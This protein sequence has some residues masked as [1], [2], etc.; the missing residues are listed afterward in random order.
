MG[1]SSSL[2]LV[3]NTLSIR[4]IGVPE[5]PEQYTHFVGCDIVDV[6]C[7]RV[8]SWPA[9]FCSPMRILI[10]FASP[11]WESNE[12]IINENSRIIESLRLGRGNRGLGR[13]KH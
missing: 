3:R 1:S 11:L 5:G 7:E 4:D 13:K 2:S 8:E 9:G 12:S 10:R 6:G